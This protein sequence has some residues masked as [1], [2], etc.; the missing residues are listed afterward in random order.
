DF[1]EVGSE[2]RGHRSDGKFQALAPVE[3]DARRVRAGPLIGQFASGL[4]RSC[5]ERGLLRLVPAL[6]QLELKCQVPADEIGGALGHSQESPMGLG[7]GVFR[8][9]KGG[10][11]QTE[12]FQALYSGGQE[13]SPGWVRRRGRR[14]GIARLHARV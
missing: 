13:N 3:Q 1:L 5:T 7:P 10:W 9:V 11:K 12:R 8:D 6:D 14:G 4:L 2:D